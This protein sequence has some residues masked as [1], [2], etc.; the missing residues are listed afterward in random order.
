MRRDTEWLIVEQRDGFNIYGEKIS[1]SREAFSFS[2]LI[3]VC[4]FTSIS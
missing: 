3:N 1:A 2:Q 4:T